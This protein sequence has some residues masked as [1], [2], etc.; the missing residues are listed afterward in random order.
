[1]A[2]KQKK[3]RAQFWEEVKN[4][5]DANLNVPILVE[6]VRF[7]R[8]K[9]MK[10]VNTAR[11]NLLHVIADVERD[12]ALRERLK[13]IIADVIAEKNAESLFAESG[14]QSGKGFIQEVIRKLREKVL[15]PLPDKESLQ[16]VL[17]RVFSNL[18][19]YVWVKGIEDEWWMQLFNLLSTDRSD[20]VKEKH[21]KNLIRAINRLSYRIASVGYET[22]IVSRFSNQD[23]FAIPFLQQNRRW[24]FLVRQ[25]HLN[26]TFRGEQ[27]NETIDLVRHSIKECK[28]NLYLLKETNEESGTSLEQTYQLQRTYQQIKRME[29]LLDLL[30]ERVILDEEL[31]LVKT[32]KEFVFH[33][34]KR[35]SLRNLYQQNI[36][37]LAYQITEHKSET[38]EHYITSNL[39]EYVRFFYAAAGGG[40][41]VAF[42]ALFKALLHHVHMALFWQYFF[43]GLNY[44]IAFVIIFATHTSLATKQ[45]AMTAT[46]LARSLDS[47]KTG[48]VSL[49][50]LALTFGK[51]WRSQFIAFVGNLIVVFPLSY[52]LMYGLDYFFHFKLLSPAESVQALNDQNPARSL[53]WLYASITGVALFLS[54]IIS[55][56]FDNLVSY[57]KIGPRIKVHPGLN[58]FFSHK[59]LDKIANYLDANLGGLIGNITLGFMLGYA[60]LVGNFF[61]IPFDIRHITISTAYYAFGVLGLEHHLSD[62]MWIGTTIGVLG[63]GFFNFLVSFSLAFYVA[64]KSRGLGMRQLPVVGVLILR[65]FRQ[66]PVDFVFP[67][68]YERKEEEVFPELEQ[69]EALGAEMEERERVNLPS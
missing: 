30:D 63:I 31:R 48:K 56:Y 6:L 2:K 65:Y 69:Q 46:A 57:A 13:G 62:G 36:G 28:H 32:F 21:L 54:G 40:V 35:Y 16:Y 41:I 14:V 10:D 23:A 68:P 60:T 67:P 25:V 18:H 37:M 9:R 20:E 27:M 12:H 59:R 22:D 24:S 7:I 58:Q 34:N 33:E 26:A 43:Y 51:V 52:A 38:G 3:T 5:R 15:P 8:P 44:A 61:G 45:P 29:L 17:S 47:R 11:E 39:K 4:G 1:M 55:G 66:Y 42:A 49:H 53:A 19:D 64:V 50:G